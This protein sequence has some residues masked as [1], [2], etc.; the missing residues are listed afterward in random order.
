MK[1]RSYWHRHL[2]VL[3]SKAVSLKRATIQRHET[4]NNYLINSINGFEEGWKVHEA[5]LLKYELKQAKLTN[6]E[7]STDDEG[8]D[9]WRHMKTGEVTSK[10]PGHKYFAHNKKAMRQKAESKF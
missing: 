4:I 7:K 6:Y 2:S 10:N 8:N 5:A 3:Q 1:E 9:F